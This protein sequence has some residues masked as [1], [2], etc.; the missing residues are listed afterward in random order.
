MGEG[1]SVVLNYAANITAAKC[2]PG[3]FQLCQ[4]LKAYNPDIFIIYR[5]FFHDCPAPAYY[6]RA[7][8]WWVAIRDE[9]PAGADAYEFEN[10]CSPPDDLFPQWVQFSID[11]AQI[12]QQQR[13]AAVLAF[14]FGPGHPNTTMW[15]ALIPYIQW[16]AAHPLPDGR[17]HGIAIHSSPYATFARAD[18]PWVNWI[19][20]AGR[21]NLARDV[22][23]A[24][25]GPDLKSWP[26][27]LWVTEIGL[28]DGY[29]GTWKAPYTCTEAA[30]AYHTTL[31]RYAE[32]GMV[33]GITWWNFGAIQPW[34]SDHDCA[35]E[36]FTALQ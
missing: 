34:S 24:N 3:S 33:T 17:F 13:N 1:A 16:V 28:G 20:I 26:G 36:M 7:W 21:M 12:V 10:E 11:M 30:D 23:L 2:L 25:G 6:T 35:D 14:S 19:Y 29:S 9:M 8:D 18:M 27:Q 15:P 4:T 32:E 22:V 31:K 5:S